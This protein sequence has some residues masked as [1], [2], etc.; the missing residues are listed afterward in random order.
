MLRVFLRYY[1]CGMKNDSEDNPTRVC[2][3]YSLKFVCVLG[4]MGFYSNPHLKD[5]CGYG[6]GSERYEERS[7]NGERKSRSRE[8]KCRTRSNNGYS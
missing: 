3:K 7:N 6:G 5:L 4:M 1:A 2:N 8:N